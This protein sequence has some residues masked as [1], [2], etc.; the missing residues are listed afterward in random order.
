MRTILSVALSGIALVSGSS[1][2]APSESPEIGGTVEHIAIAIDDGSTQPPT[3]EEET[4]SVLTT[5]P[6][7]GAVDA[8]D[9]DTVPPSEFN[10]TSTTIQPEATGVSS[11]IPYVDP[12]ASTEAVDLAP[13]EAGEDADLPL[14]QGD[15]EER[16]LETATENLRLDT[17]AVDDE[18]AS[19]DE[20]VETAEDDEATDGGA[21]GEVTHV[22]E[23][24]EDPSDDVTAFPYQDEESSTTAAPEFEQ[25]TDMII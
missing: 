5:P 25:T 6:A 17:P 2:E 22:E 8:V 23:V 10:S 24:N 18:Q 11:E 3:V 15:G 14:T 13:V 21:N 1:V 20:G 4:N 9:T 19:S 7:L 12:V 16:G